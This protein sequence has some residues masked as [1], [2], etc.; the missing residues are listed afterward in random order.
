MLAKMSA[1]IG[2]RGT[3]KYFSTFICYFK[4]FISTFVAMNKMNL[5][6][7]WWWLFFVRN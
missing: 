3:E 1:C 2:F 5:N 6:N 7:N 4:H